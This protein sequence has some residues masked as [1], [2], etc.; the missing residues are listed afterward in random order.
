MPVQSKTRPKQ[1][2]SDI[3]LYNHYGNDM[4]I[5]LKLIFAVESIYEVKSVQYSQ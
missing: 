2:R 1:Y 5:V 3:R 4:D